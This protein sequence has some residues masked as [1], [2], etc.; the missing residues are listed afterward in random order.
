MFDTMELA[1]CI[2]VIVFCLAK[3]KK[4]CTLNTVSYSIVF[5]FLI[6]KRNKIGIVYFEAETK[7]NKAYYTEIPFFF[8]KDFANE[9]NTS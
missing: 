4:E 5:F 2:G 8:A 3:L 7:F 9:T 6:S 1:I